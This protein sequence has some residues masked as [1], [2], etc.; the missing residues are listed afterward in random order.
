MLR[1]ER[2]LDRLRANA[3]RFGQ[4]AEVRQPRG[5][6]DDVLGVIDE[7]FGQEA[8][9]EV[10]A[11]LVVDLL[12]GEIVAPDLVVNGSTRPP[13]RARDKV[14]GLHLGHPVA[15]LHDLPEALMADDQVLAPRRRVAVERLVDLSIRSVDTDLEHLHPHGPALRDLTDVR[16]RLIGQLRFGNL[17]QVDAVRLPGQ[18]GNGFHRVGPPGMG[19][20]PGGSCAGAACAD[21][22][23]VGWTSPGRSERTKL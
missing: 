11:A 2:L 20:Q 17:S 15:H 21:T 19:F 13:D 22:Q 4:D 12:P 6:P 23:G 5:N 1:Q 14:A 10:D 8:V 18:D 9:A 16:M 3:R 7:V